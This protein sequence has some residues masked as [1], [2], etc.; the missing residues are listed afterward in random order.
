MR[1][2]NY[3]QERGDRNRAKETKKQARLQQRTKA[4]DERKRSR[5]GDQPV[6]GF[7]DDQGGDKR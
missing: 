6:E 7:T 1:P 3:Q 5:E 2:P 4:A